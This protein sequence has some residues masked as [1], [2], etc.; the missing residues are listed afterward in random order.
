MNGDCLLSVL[1]LLGITVLARYGWL[2]YRTLATPVRIRQEGGTLLLRETVMSIAYHLA[3]PLL[4]ELSRRNFRANQ[5]TWASLPLGL[6]AGTFA[7]FGI[8][9]VAALFLLLS[10]LCDLLDGALARKLHKGGPT[11]EKTVIYSIS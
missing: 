9:S 2:R 8:W 6:L 10:G 3:M 7:A 11:L 5:V 4:D 1:L